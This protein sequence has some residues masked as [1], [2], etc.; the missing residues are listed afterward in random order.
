M[1]LYRVICTSTGQCPK[2]ASL[3]HVER[4]GLDGPEGSDVFDVGVARLM[5]SSGDTLTLGK[6]GDEDAELRKGKCPACGAATLR[7][8][9]RGPP[10]DLASLNPC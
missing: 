1:G 3:Y 9:K 10:L 8:R 4:I 6:R 5:I 7:G 2:D